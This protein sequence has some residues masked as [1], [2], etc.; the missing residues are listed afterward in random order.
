MFR[1][2]R[3]GAAHLRPGELEDD[4]GPLLISYAPCA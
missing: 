3:Q 1:Q 4:S 2:A